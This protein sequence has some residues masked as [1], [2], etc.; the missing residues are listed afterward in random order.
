MGTSK[1]NIGPIGYSNPIQDWN[2]DNVV[3]NDETNSNQDN[4]EQTEDPS[5]QLGK[6][7]DA[8]KNFSTFIK[9]PTKSNYKKFTS[10]YKKASG[11]NKKLSRSSI[12]GR[13]GAVVLLDF[14]TRIST[15]GFKETL[16]NFNIGDIEQLQTEGAVNKI[17][18]IFADID[19]T[20]EGS[21]ATSAAIETINKLYNDY[22]E[23]PEL[24]GSLDINL[25]SEYL[26]FYLSSYIFERISIEV[27]KALEDNKLSIQ[28]V[29]QAEV[30]LKSYIEAEVQL[31]FKDIDFSTKNINEQNKIVHQIFNDAYSLI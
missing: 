1:A 5:Q 26:Q 3:I 8:K 12:G 7:G 21:A 30:Y 16:Q 10:S 31:N 22:S 4:S 6:W 2:T 14:L 27:S 29:N 28:Q 24:L 23:S 17:S 15:D 11:G 18:K 19:G 25:I 20:D 13:K 9:S